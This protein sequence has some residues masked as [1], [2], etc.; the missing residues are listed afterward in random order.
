[1]PFDGI[2]FF[3]RSDE[4]VVFEEKNAKPSVAKVRPP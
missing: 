1:M 2:E 3:L 4:L